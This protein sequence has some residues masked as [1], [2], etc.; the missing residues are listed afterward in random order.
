MNDLLFEMA[1]KSAVLNL[2]DFADRSGLDAQEMAA[3]LRHP[4][5]RHMLQQ[6]IAE[7]IRLGISGTPAFVVDGNVYLGQLP[8]EVLESY[9]Y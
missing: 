2:Q 8:P 7:G 1:Q 9:L 3:A 4:R 5:M 6:D